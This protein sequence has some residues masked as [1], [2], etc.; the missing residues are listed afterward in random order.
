MDQFNDFGSMYTYLFGLYQE[1]KYAEALA[2]AER[3]F[4]H[5]PQNKPL[6]Y[7][8]RACM[9][10]RL[11]DKTGALTVLNTAID[12][13]LWYPEYYW[14]DDDLTVLRGDPDF[15]RLK[16]ISVERHTEAQKSSKPELTVFVPD[17]KKHLPLLIAL[18]GN[19]GNIEQSETAWNSAMSAGWILALPQSSQISA[20]NAFIWNDT[21]VADRELLAH[22]D[23][24]C[25]QY[26]P[27]DTQ[28]LILG[29]F[30][31]G[32]ETVIR[33]ALQGLLP[34]RGFIA[35]TP[36]GPLTQ[37]P[38]SWKPIIEAAQDKKVR[39]VFIIGGK[40]AAYQQTRELAQMLND[41]GIE[42]QVLDYPEMGHTFPPDFAERLPE[43]LN[44][45][46]GK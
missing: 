14:T 45:I 30:S 44:F 41:T 5:F 33:A 6:M 42:C 37:N 40:D 26:G 36:G 3:E 46:A 1:G 43:L 10:G 24:V 12:A 35:V 23:T 19:N 38:E 22:Y 29:G 25:H 7:H 13:G 15:E 17:E 4:E 11:N 27:I 8:F 34:T 16:A 20:P 9:S 32:G 31:M 39:G 2:I 18:H 21:A 28:H